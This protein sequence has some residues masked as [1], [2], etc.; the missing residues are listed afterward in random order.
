MISVNYEAKDIGIN[1]HMS[2]E[3]AKDIAIDKRI[4]LNIFKTPQKYDKPYRQIYTEAGDQIF[5]V[6]LDFIEKLGDIGDSIMIESVSEDDILLDI[7]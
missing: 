7:T 5:D 4:R 6:I 3:E 2:I 1:R